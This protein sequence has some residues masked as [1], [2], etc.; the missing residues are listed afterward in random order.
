M[1]HLYT[2]QICYSFCKKLSN[3]YNNSFKKTHSF[4]STPWEDT[5]SVHS[6]ILLYI[7]IYLKTFSKSNINHITEKSL[8]AVPE[9]NILIIAAKIYIVLPLAIQ[10]QILVVFSSKYL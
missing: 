6:L 8:I 1:E 3:Q 4:S 10:I 9:K 7:Y 2:T 5:L